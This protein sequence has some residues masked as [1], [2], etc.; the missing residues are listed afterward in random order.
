MSEDNYQ[1][2]SPVFSAP[3]FSDAGF[4]TEKAW[5]TSEPNSKPKIERVERT[6]DPSFT[7]PVLLFGWNNHP[8]VTPDFH[9]LN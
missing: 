7:C 1:P 2:I 8:L 6:F 9:C 3:P 4:A 5:F